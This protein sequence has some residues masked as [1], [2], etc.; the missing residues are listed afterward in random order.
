MS[1]IP[2]P[3]PNQM[4]DDELEEQISA[5]SNVFTGHI[6]DVMRIA[7][8]IQVLQAEQQRRATLVLREATQ[9]FQ[10]ASVAASGELVKAINAFKSESAATASRLQF[11][12]WVLVGL[13]VALLAVTVA[14]IVTT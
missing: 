8:K 14:L 5:L 9:S 7:P 1:M 11:A 4:S 12:T 10:V 6:N 2:G 13:T 3:N